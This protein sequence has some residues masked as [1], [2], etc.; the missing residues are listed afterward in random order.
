MIENTNKI[1]TIKNKEKEENK[2]KEKKKIEIEHKKLNPGNIKQ[3][4]TYHKFSPSQK[5][6]PSMLN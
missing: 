2:R 1:V 5:I 6:Y 3:Y 4:Q